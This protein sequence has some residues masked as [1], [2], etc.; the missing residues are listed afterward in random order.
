[1]STQIPSL[2]LGWFSRT[3][4]RE[5]TSAPKV[6]FVS[7]P[8]GRRGNTGTVNNLFPL[9]GS[10]TLIG[11]HGLFSLP[12][13]EDSISYMNES[14]SN[15]GRG[16]GGPAMSSRHLVHGFWSHTSTDQGRGRADKLVPSLLL[17]S[18][19]KALCSCWGS[20]S[21]SQRTSVTSKLCCSPTRDRELENSLPYPETRMTCLAGALSRDV[22]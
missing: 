5:F 14:V 18:G 20:R 21:G 11:P 3:R 8:V 22:N 17:A 2:S 19:T 7:L 9:P 10:M 4:G 12:R 15:G 13:H 6:L 1:M 16:G